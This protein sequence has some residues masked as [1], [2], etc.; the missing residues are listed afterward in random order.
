VAGCAAPGEGLRTLDDGVQTLEADDLLIC[1]I[2]RPVAIAGVM[3]GASSEVAGSTT[4]VL[5]ESAYFTRTGI[6]R[7]ARRLA[8]HSEASHRYERGTDPE[9]LDLTSARCASLIAEWAGG[10]VLGG[11]VRHGSPPPRRWVSMRPSRASALLGYEVSSAEAGSVFDTLGFTHRDQ[12]DAIEVEVP[13]YRVDIDREVDLIEEVAR[14]QGY[15]RIGTLVPSAGQVG[16]VPHRYAY[17]QRLRD[18]A[19]GAGLR[20]VRQLSFASERD[21]TLMGEGGAD[22]AK[23]ARHGER[24][25][26]GRRRHAV[27]TPVGGLGPSGGCGFRIHPDHCLSPPHS[28]ERAYQSKPSHILIRPDHG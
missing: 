4:T 22:A 15:D 14:T 25:S 1:G 28:N 19:V 24:L 26:P 23:D 12:G 7:T 5:L 2:E 13:G 3:G 16:G 18:A 21:L 11:V 20:E 6:L 27:A 10:S 17:R 9:Q 8:L